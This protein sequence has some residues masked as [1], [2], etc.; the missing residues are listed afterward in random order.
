MNGLK[1]G[2]VHLTAIYCTGKE[3]KKKLLCWLINWSAKLQMPAQSFVLDA[4]CGKGRYSL[5]LAEKGFDV[6]GI[7]ICAAAITEAKKYET[8]KLHFYL[9]D[10]RLPFYI[11]YFDYAFN[12]FTSF[13]YFKTAR[14]HNDAMRTL[15]QSLKLNGFLIIDYLNT[16]FTEEHLKH[17]DVLQLEGVDFNIER[18]C[19][20]EYFYKRI[21]VY[22][23]AKN[24]NET[25]T[26]QVEKFSLG[27]FTDMLS[28][29][30]L[31]IEDVFGDY[32]L[33]AYHVKKSPRMIIVAKKIH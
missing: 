3:I 14:E 1:Y 16:H 15:A 17:E 19:D 23:T 33:N 13:G 28:F 26:E 20:E 11:N 7:D 30:G 2:L 29:Q 6:M 12:F 10:L 21:H 18:W 31:V 24:V 9:H 22:D 4:A 27:D 32:D 5:A 8:D 25:F